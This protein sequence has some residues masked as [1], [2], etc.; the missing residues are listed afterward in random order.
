MKTIERLLRRIAYVGTSWI[1]DGP[2]PPGFTGWRSRVL[3]AGIAFGWMSR[4]GRYDDRTLYRRTIGNAS[5]R[6]HFRFAF[7]GKFRRAS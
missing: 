4:G 2:T 5:A 1:V 6:A 3:H 7:T